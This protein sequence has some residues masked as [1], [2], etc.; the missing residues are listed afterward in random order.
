V[1]YKHRYKDTHK[2]WNEPHSSSQLGLSAAMLSKRLP[3]LARGATSHLLL[4]FRLLFHPRGTSSRSVRLN[5]SGISCATDIPDKSQTSPP[6]IDLSPMNNP[7]TPVEY[8]VGVVRNLKPSLPSGCGLLGQ[9][10]LKIAGSH[11]I[12]AGGFADVWVGE[13]NDGTTVAI[14]SYRYYSSSS[15]LPVYLVSVEPCR[16]AFL[17][18]IVTDRGCTTKH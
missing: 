5:W 8:I 12:D 7:N 3:L 1:K 4:C 16:N 18:L 2:L 15:C 13:M 11:P 17:S 9:G 14:K 6:E 10:D